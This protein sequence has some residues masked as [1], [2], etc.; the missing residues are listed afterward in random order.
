VIIDP[1]GRVAHHFKKVKAKGH[2]GKVKDVLEG[3]VK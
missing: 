1:D 3:L 2:A